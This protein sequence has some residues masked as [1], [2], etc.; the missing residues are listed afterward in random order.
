M[1]QLKGLKGMF[2]TA[3]YMFQFQY[4]A[5]ESLIELLHIEQKPRFNSS[6]VQLKGAIVFVVNPLSDVSIPVWCSWKLRP[7]QFLVVLISFNSSMVQLKV[8][9][10]G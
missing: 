10:V 2:Y 1:V 5:A 8:S 7:C 9:I 4:G 3:K 6:M